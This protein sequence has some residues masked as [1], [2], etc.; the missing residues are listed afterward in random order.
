MSV[1]INRMVVI[2]KWSQMYDV[3]A[4]GIHENGLLHGADP[5]WTSTGASRCRQG[6]KSVTLRLTIG[7][8]GKDPDLHGD[9]GVR[10]RRHEE[11]RQAPG[12]G[13]AHPVTNRIFSL[14]TARGKIA[15]TDG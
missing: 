6:K 9:R 1:S 3:I 4:Q 12:R 5:L 8:A 13:A 2:V 10:L 7:S 14:F 15:Y 11:A